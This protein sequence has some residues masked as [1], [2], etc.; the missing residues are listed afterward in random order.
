MLRPVPAVSLLLT[1]C[2]ASAAEVNFNRDIRPVLT[3]NCFHCH[4]PDPSSRKANLRLDLA[5]E[6]V[7]PAKSGAIPIVPGKPEESEVLKRI[8]HSDPDEVM[9]PADTHKTITPQQRELLRQWIAAGAKYEGHWAFTK[10]VR[11]PV[12]EVAGAP[13]GAVRNSIDAFILTRLKETVLSP[14]PA[15]DQHTLARRAALDLT[16][17]P[18]SPED[19]AAFLA[20]ESSQAWEHYIDRLLASPHYGERWARVWMDIARYADSAGY[21]S[22]PL[23]LNIW[24]WRDWVIKAFNQNLSWDQF[25]FDQLAGDLA[26]QATPEQMVATAFHRNTMTNTEG[27][28]DDEEWRVAAVKDRAGVTAQ[29]WMGLTMNCAQCHTHKFDPIS[30]DEYY[31]FYALFNQTEDNDQPDERPLFPVP[32]SGER[33][34]M[35]TLQ[36]EI[37]ALQ[38][39]SRGTTPELEK[40]LIAWEQEQARAIA[41]STLDITALTTPRGRSLTWEKL[42]DGSVLTKNTPDRRVTFEVTA[43]APIEKLTGLRLE[44]LPHESLPAHGPGHSEGGNAVISEVSLAVEPATA[45][46]PRV[47]YVRVESPGKQRFLHLAE[48][49]VFSGSENIAPRGKASQSSTDF[50]GAASRGNDGDTNGVF[51]QNSVTHTASDDDPWWEVDLGGNRAVDHIVV[52]NRAEAAERLTGWRIV[53]LDENRQPLW[54]QDVKDAP[55]PSFTSQVKAGQ[56]GVF[57]R[58]SADF[59]QEGWD[60]AKAIDGNGDTG[61]AWSPRPGQEH[62]AI[63][64][65]ERPLDRDVAEAK[66][67]I[68]LAQNFGSRHAVGRFRLSVT[69]DSGPLEVL[70]DHLRPIL[71][72]PAEQRTPDQHKSLL[73]YY[74]PRSRAMAAVNAT[75]KEKQKALEAIKPVAVPVMRELSAEKRR[76]TF[77]MNKGN[78]LDPGAEMQPGFPAAFGSLPP[79]TR[80]D[81]RGVVQWLFSPENPLTARVTVNRFWAQLFGTGL[82]ETEEDFGLQGTFPSHPELLDWLAVEFRDHGWDVKR[83]LKL[84]VTSATYRQSSALPLDSPVAELD[85]NNRLLS[86]YPRRRLDAEQVRDQALALSGLLS[87]KLGG[88]SVYPP[89]P[90]GLWKAAFNGERTYTTSQGEDRHRRGLYTI[91]RRTTPYPSMATFDAPSREACTLRRIPT[92]TPLQAYVTL[93]DPVFVEAAQALGRRIV[94]EG[95]PDT[96]SRLRYAISLTLYRPADPA[97]LD[98]LTGL[99]ESELARYSQDLEAATKLSTEPLGPLPVSLT[100][101]EAAA[102]TTVANVLLNL[103][104]VL[105]KG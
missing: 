43:R 38:A 99:Y 62:T 4:G 36:T 56:S 57:S 60:V 23:R 41:W 83:L 101:A 78:F 46:E 69:D 2:A 66:L 87:R 39:A 1:V 14:A 91:W 52:W 81:R 48:V 50:G 70:P 21:G 88:P 5:E 59:S 94:K 16:G 84:I 6:A 102:W 73:D 27:G 33:S 40:E 22:D 19:Y 34:A 45:P 89:Q 11:P 95:G 98:A 64:Q 32:S 42:P 13:A 9:P 53:T 75:L 68:T 25:T 7:K 85:P 49:Q 104:G 10:P 77:L 63:F 51:T 8:L 54:H 92:N 58:A 86:R 65:L 35:E 100:P 37:T 71:A 55:S 105:M 12:P 26:D 67:K 28:T 44:V 20:D 31:S 24:P 30:H 47:R 93:N 61:W 18:P 74:R 3:E 82:V 15:A 96:A 79:G 76:R 72:L 90:D 103:D 97:V 29:A 80:M 17:L